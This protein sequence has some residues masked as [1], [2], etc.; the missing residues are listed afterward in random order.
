[1]AWL[2]PVLLAAVACTPTIPASIARTPTAIPTLTPDPCSTA[3][4]PASV[5]PLNDLMRQFDDDATVAGNVV[6]SQIAELLPRMQAIRQTVQEQPVPACLSNLKRFEL[7]YMDSTLQ[8][9]LAFKQ[10]TPSVSAAG[11]GIVQSRQYHNQYT[12]ELGRLFGFELA[13]PTALPSVTSS[14]P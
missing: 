10:P 14:T 12:G 6:Q 5:K 9:L 3:N 4:L 7:L 2:L 11:T 1:M 13:S 8:T